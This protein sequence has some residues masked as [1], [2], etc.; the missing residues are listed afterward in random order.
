M[1]I[2]DEMSESEKYHKLKFVEFLEFVARIAEFVFEKQTKM[3][4]YDKVFFTMQKMFAVIPAPA[5]EPRTE[6]DIV[7]ESDDEEYMN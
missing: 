1:T 5:L 2:I 4:L 6:I 7:S 3:K